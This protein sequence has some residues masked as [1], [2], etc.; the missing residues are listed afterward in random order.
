MVMF[1]FM[2]SR[3]SLRA[4]KEWCCGCVYCGLGSGV[5]KRLYSGWSLGGVRFASRLRRGDGRF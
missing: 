5:G 1:M 2:G 3:E 4:G